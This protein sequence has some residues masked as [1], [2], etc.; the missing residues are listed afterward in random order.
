MK[1]DFTQN[2]HG[3][4]DIPLNTLQKFHQVLTES[5][6]ATQRHTNRRKIKQLNSSKHI[7]PF[8]DIYIRAVMKWSVCGSVYYLCAQW[9]F[10]L[11]CNLCPSLTPI[12]SVITTLGMSR[13]QPSFVRHYAKRKAGGKPHNMHDDINNVGSGRHWPRILIFANMKEKRV[14]NFINSLLTS[15]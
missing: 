13:T 1:L 15:F 7:I 2:G 4:I 10:L 12:R 9:W 3:P 11:P 6:Q 14:N 8:I 5:S